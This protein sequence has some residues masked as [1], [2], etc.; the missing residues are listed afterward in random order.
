M[1]LSLRSAMK[2]S[3]CLGLLSALATSTGYAATAPVCTGAGFG[4]TCVKC[5]T[6]A[7]YD[8]ATK[9]IGACAANRC[10]EA[11]KPFKPPARDENTGY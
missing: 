5:D 9:K 6:G 2:L 7:C 4:R 10:G 11:A 1:S 3:L 8:T